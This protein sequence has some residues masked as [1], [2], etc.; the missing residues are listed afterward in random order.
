M[1]LLALFGWMGWEFYTAAG[2]LVWPT[3]E[4]TVRTMKVWEKAPLG[5]GN[6]SFQIEITY[7]Y[8]V[9][10]RTYTGQTFNSR[11][12]HIDEPAIPTIRQQYAVGS[13]CEVAYSPMVPA[14]SVLVR[15]VSVTAWGKL[16]IGLVALGA[17]VYCLILAFQ[18]PKAPPA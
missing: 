10:G 14:Q 15:E 4:G 11:N 8:S 3:T 9:G 5:G 7:E 2:S 13:R 16:A 12:N 17:A 1:V 18:K 6:K